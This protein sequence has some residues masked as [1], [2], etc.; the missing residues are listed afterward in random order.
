MNLLSLL[1]RG[2]AGRSS[3]V[4]FAVRRLLLAGFTGRNQKIAMKH[5]EELREHGVEAPKKIPAFYAVPNHLVVTGGDIEVLG[6]QTSGEVEPVLL[7]EK[8]TIYLGVG[9]DHTDRELE[10]TSI[11]KSK[12]MCAKVLAPELWDFK[13]VQS[14]WD[15][16]RLRSWIGDGRRKRLYQDAELSAFLPPRKLMRL[17]QTHVRDRKLD[18][19]MLFLGTVPVIGRGFGFASTFTGELLDQSTKRTLSFSYRIKPIGWLK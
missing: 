1:V 16:L 10:K 14:H 18:G 17:T 13:E 19:M 9:S 3:P 8:E 6:N 4:D 7:F 11:A 12:V 2:G 15:G 5:V